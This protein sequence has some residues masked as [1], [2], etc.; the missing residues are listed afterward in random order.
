MNQTLAGSA[1]A[2]TDYASRY[3]RSELFDV[4]L[5]QN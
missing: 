4:A 1:F 3:A 5:M 2:K